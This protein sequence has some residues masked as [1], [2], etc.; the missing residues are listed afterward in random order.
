MSAHPHLPTDGFCIRN[1]DRDFREWHRGRLR[2]VLWAI[3]VGVPA[4]QSRIS[5]AQSHLDG[6][7]LENY[8]RQ[9]HITLTLCGFPGVQPL[10]PDEF[11]RSLLEKQ[12]A[13]LQQSQTAPF[14][15]TIDDLSSF[16][17]APYL[18]VTDVSGGIAKL[19]ACVGSGSDSQAYVPHVTVGLYADAW[20]TKTVLL[21][22]TAFVPCAALPLR[23]T[24]IGLFAYQ[25]SSIG[26]RLD[27]LATYDL[28]DRRL[29]WQG[30]PLFV[31]EPLTEP[32]QSF[33]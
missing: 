29:S 28:E 20:P 11:D 14:D 16:G 31:S 8:R 18:R 24:R 6:L 13:S 23:V 5:T 7:L 25:A 1:V 17:S 2:Y 3:D 12:V 30:M 4:V 10:L 9:P 32:R 33:T 26:G 19:R 22:L 27:C 15:I 21:R